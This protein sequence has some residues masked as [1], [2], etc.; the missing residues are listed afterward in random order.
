[1]IACYCRVSTDDQSLERQ[2]DATTE[3]AQTRLGAALSDIE[4]YRDRSTGTDTARRGYRELMNNVD[5]GTIDAVVVN[6]VSRISR[7]IRDLDRTAER[8]ADGRAELHILAEG[9]TMR[10]DDNDPYQKALFRLLGVFAELEA[11]MVQQ[12]TREGIAARQ[13]EENY[14]H[15]R[16]PLGFQKEDGR[17]LEGEN[18]DHV[19][20]VLDM[21]QKEEIS[22]RQAAREL[23]T[24]RPTVDRALK[25]TDLYGL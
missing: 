11:E 20:T 22:K 1:M 17:L 3:Y 23:G 6:S 5:A 25:R 21:V 16:P 24:S 15:G 9:L 7:S 13:R 14:H 4:V 12:R 19:V 2:I 8:V 10:P 18:Y